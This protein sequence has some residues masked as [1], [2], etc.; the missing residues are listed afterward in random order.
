MMMN[1]CLGKTKFWIDQCALF[2]CVVLNVQNVHM[3]EQ[4]NWDAHGSFHQSKTLSSPD[5]ERTLS[6]NVDDLHTVLQRGIVHTV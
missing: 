5:W 3:D 6:R 4:T 2:H 1:T